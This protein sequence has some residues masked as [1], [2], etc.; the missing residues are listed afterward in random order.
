MPLSYCAFEMI[1]LPNEYSN[2]HFSTTSHFLGVVWL[3]K[4]KSLLLK[5]ICETSDALE[6]RTARGDGVKMSDVVNELLCVKLSNDN[7]EAVAS[8]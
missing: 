2:I 8:R 3:L 4:K 6:L 7:Q 5:A 1:A